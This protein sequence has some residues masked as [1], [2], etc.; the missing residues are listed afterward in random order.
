M[1][2][3]IYFSILNAY[4]QEYNQKLVN[5]PLQ[6]NISTSVTLELCKVQTQF[7]FLKPTE[8]VIVKNLSPTS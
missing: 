7:G 5:P 4:L 2:V 8:W 3:F 1:A 6:L